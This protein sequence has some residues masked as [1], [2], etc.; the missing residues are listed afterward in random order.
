MSKK[1]Y[2]YEANINAS[3]G[4]ITIPF[5]FTYWGYDETEPLD[6]AEDLLKQLF[7]R[8]SMIVVRER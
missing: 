5:D 6:Q 1:H 3:D 8:A 7:P 4:F 2:P